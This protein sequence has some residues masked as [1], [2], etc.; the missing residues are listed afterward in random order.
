MKTKKKREKLTWAKFKTFIPLYLMLLPGLIYF[1]INN[2]MPMT[3]IIVA[4]KKYSKRKGIFGSDWCGLDNFEYLF[5]ND[6]GII[7]RNTLLYNVVFIILGMVVGVALAI[8]ITDVYSRR[9]KKI[10]QSAILLP[11]LISIVI[12]SYIVF[13][14]LSV[15]NGMINNGI[16]KPLGFDPVQW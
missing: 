3:G 16:L 11:F 8:L 15:E 12:V 10:Y 9:G 2:Y 1:F 4:F 5:K 14:F 7:I 6:A 13:A